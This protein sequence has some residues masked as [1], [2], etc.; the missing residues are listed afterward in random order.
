MKEMKSSRVRQGMFFQCV[1][2]Q[3][4]MVDRHT[5]AHRLGKAIAAINT[6]KPNLLQ[7]ILVRLVKKVAQLSKVRVDSSPFV[8]SF[9]F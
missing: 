6:L 5:N 2:S 4:L 7:K 1:I 3:F 8:C 9:D